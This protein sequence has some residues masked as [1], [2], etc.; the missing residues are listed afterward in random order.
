MGCG[1]EDP[2]TNPIDLGKQLKCVMSLA[3][4]AAKRITNCF[5]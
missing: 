4:T 3:G 1:I 5:R 2:I